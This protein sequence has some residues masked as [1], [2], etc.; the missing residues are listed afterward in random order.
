MLASQDHL[1]SIQF[2][3]FDC[4]SYHF[5]KQTKF[6]FN[7]SDYFSSTPFY[8]IHSDIWGLALVPIEGGSRYFVIFV[9]DFC[10]YIW[11]Y[12]L[13]HRSELVSIYQTFHRMIETQFNHTIKIFRSDNAQEYDDKYFLSFLDNKGTLSH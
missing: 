12:P 9:D 11:I 2:P 4:T 6:P 3:K 1:G 8:L 13:H 10:R 5:G 7:N